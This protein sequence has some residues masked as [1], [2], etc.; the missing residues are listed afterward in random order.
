MERINKLYVIIGMVISLGLFYSIAADADEADEATTITFSA[1]VEIPGHVLP[2]GTYLFKLADD[3]SD[4]NVVQIFN[5]AGTKLYD[6][7]P[8]TPAEREQPSGHTAVTLVQQ[9]SAEPDVLLKWFYPGSA[10][11]HEFMYS[12]QEDKVLAQDKQQT[13]AAGP[14]TRNSETQAGD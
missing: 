12:T 10:I 14:R 7:L 6:M 11:G 13:I 1:P 2:A 8:T 3:G 5:S 9:G 4:P